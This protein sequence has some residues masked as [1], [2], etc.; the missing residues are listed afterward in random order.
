MFKLILGAL[1][2]LGALTEPQTKICGSQKDLCHLYLL[3]AARNGNSIDILEL[4]HAGAD[5]N[6][7]D[8]LGRSALQMAAIYN[9]I[10]AADI[11]IKLGANIDGGVLQKFTALHL[12]AAAGNDYM[13]RYLRN[14]GADVNLKDD[15]GNTALYIAAKDGQTKVIEALTD[16]DPNL[17]AKAKLN[18]QNSDGLTAL[19]IA[20][21]FGHKEAVLAL[22][23][24]GADF[25]ISDQFGQT[26]IFVAAIEGHHEL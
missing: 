15:F 20:V 18:E 14:S 8:S 24:A 3:E 13:V 10:P 7:A 12:A 11:L 17:P 23:K 19:H 21:F 2:T 1:A 5:I 6:G 25:N 4:A 26:P 9:N 22:L 16:N